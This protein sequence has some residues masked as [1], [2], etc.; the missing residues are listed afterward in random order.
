M[1]HIKPYKDI[2]VQIGDYVLTKSPYDILDK[3]L[4]KNFGK[5]LPKKTIKQNLAW[6]EYSDI[7]TSL[8]RP[9]FDTDNSRLFYKSDIIRKATPEEVKQIELTKAIDKYNL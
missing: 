5:I 2:E 6:I 9:Y 8:I 1:K 4:S 7:P 3:F